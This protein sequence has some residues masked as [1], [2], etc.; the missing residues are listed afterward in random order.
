MPA[1]IDATAGSAA[2][3]AYLTEAEAT[4]YLDGRVDSAAWTTATPDQ[5]IRAIISATR[6]LDQEQYLG[7]KADPDQAREWP[8]FGVVVHGLFY[9]DTGTIPPRIRNGTA[10]LALALL[11]TPGL[12]DASGLEAFESV[13]VGPLEVTPAKGT[14]AGD[15]PEPV[16]REIRPLLASNGSSIRLRRG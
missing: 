12:L 8:R 11:S 10:E 16:R 4:A 9:L 1:A 3:N 13:K 15:L 14:R 5:R 2:A 7:L 6:R